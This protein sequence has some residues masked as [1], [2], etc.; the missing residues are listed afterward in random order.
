MLPDMSRTRGR[1]SAVL[2]SFTVSGSPWRIQG[3][4]RFNDLLAAESGVS[5]TTIQ[6]VGSKGYDGFTIAIVRGPSPP[7]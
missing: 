5:A 6:T 3:V 2:E 1:D 7:S 4:R